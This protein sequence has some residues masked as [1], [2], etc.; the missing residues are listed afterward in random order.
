MLRYLKQ[1]KTLKQVTAG[2][3]EP[4][5]AF[6]Y[7][8]LKV[9]NRHRAA[10]VILMLSGEFTE[11]GGASETFAVRSISQTNDTVQKHQTGRRLLDRNKEV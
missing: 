8:K 7:N 1:S 10:N 4:I 3:L 2:R 11:S 9:E 6:V 5:T